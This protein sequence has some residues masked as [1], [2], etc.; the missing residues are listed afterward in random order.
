MVGP[1]EPDHV[2]E[3]V[4]Q[5]DRARPAVDVSGMA[6]IGRISRLNKQI[7]PQLNAVFAK[8]GL[9]SWEFDV[10]ATLVRSGE[11]HQLTP[12]R[13]LKSMMITSGAMTN[14]IQRLEER[15]FVKRI[16][17][18]NDGRQVLVTLTESGRRTLDAALIDHAANERAIVSVLNKRQQAQLIGL[19]RILHHS[20]VDHIED[21][22]DP[23][24]VT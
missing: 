5:W 14:R 3:I 22:R 16:K 11:P 21:Q 1:M 4:A 9:E 10:L 6:I 7:R 2:D 19:L 13:L 15:G 24:A 17:C 23:D 18:P 20:V 12:G 8:H